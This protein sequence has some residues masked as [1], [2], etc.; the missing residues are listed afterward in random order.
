MNNGGKN[1]KSNKKLISLIMAI[2][3]VVNF[4]IFGAIQVFAR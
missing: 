1:I 2:V 4:S 3:M